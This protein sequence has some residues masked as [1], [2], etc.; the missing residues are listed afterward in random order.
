MPACP[1]VARSGR[2]STGRQK[3]RRAAGSRHRPERRGLVGFMTGSVL[4]D[5]DGAGWRAEQAAEADIVAVLAV[6]AGDLGILAIPGAMPGG[7]LPAMLLGE[8]RPWN[9]AAGGV[10]D[11]TVNVIGPRRERPTGPIR[12]RRRT[13]CFARKRSWV[14]ASLA[15]R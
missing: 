4:R 2:N 7:D 1:D 15:A 6:H 12:P 5:H 10:A 8:R 9:D 11:D 3:F 13:S 14:A